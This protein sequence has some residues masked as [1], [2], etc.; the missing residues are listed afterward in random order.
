MRVLKSI[1]SVFLFVALIVCALLLIDRIQARRYRDALDEVMQKHHVYYEQDGDI[2]NSSIAQEIYYVTETNSTVNFDVYYDNLSFY[3]RDKLPDFLNPTNMLMEYLGGDWD[4]DSL[5]KNHTIVFDDGSVIRAE[6]ICDSILH[7]SYDDGLVY[8]SNHEFYYDMMNHHYNLYVLPDGT[9]IGG[10]HQVSAFKIILGDDSTGCMAFEYDKV[11]V[12]TNGDRV[13]AF[14]L[15][16]Y[17]RDVKQWAAFDNGI[18]VFV[19][20]NENGY[21]LWHV[22]RGSSVLVEES[23]GPIL[24]DRQGIRGGSYGITANVNDHAI[25]FARNGSSVVIEAPQG[26]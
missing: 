13:D 8:S 10:G 2:P 15:G 25:T 1:I 18:F 9:R 17:F 6:I 19:T 21:Q 14:P 22:I 20:L 11:Y 4:G 26:E 5:S 16:F 12:V 3:K 7:V 24:L 23:D